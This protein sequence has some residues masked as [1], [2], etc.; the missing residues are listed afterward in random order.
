MTDTPFKT[1]FRGYDPLDVDPAFAQLRKAV[2]DSNDEVGR[3]NVELQKA[4]AEASD[5]K[6]QHAAVVARV[7]ELEEQLATVGRPSYEEF[8]TTIGRIL[9]LAEKEAQALRTKAQADADALLSD[10]AAKASA[11]TEKAEREASDLASSSQAEAARLVENARRHADEQLDHADRESS[12]RRE[13]AEAVYEQQ[14]QRATAAAADFEKTL[15]GRRDD[16][17]REFEAQHASHAEQLAAAIERR[18][19]AEAEAARILAQAQEQASAILDAAKGEASD[20]VGT[21]RSQADRIRRDSER[22]LVAATQRRDAISAQLTNV[23]QMLATLG[24]GTAFG[25][26]DDEDPVVHAV[27]E[28]ADPQA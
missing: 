19:A 1:A 24:G 11:M 28:A 25:L 13:E 3:V 12:A 14:Q 21:A 7:A 9:S 15:A 2:A 26:S 20:V 18:D 6:T 22:E 17:A 27:T 5:L 16:A 8:G 10:A 4:K 23:R